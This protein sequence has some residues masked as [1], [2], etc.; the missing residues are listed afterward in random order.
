MPI[1]LMMLTCEPSQHLNLM[2]VGRVGLSGG[3][4]GGGGVNKCFSGNLASFP[5]PLK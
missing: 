3:G 4:G 1:S 5:G 2:R